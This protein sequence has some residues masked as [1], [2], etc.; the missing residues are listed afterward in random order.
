MQETKQKD[1]PEKATESA[2]KDERLVMCYGDAEKQCIKSVCS[3][4]V[5]DD[6]CP[7]FDWLGPYKSNVYVKRPGLPDRPDGLIRINT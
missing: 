1:K 5:K 6:R 4:W 7:N 2:S 3:M